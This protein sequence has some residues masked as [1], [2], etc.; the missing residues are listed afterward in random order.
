MAADVQAL[1][2]AKTIWQ[3]RRS[4]PKTG[5]PTGYDALDQQLPQGGWCAGALTEILYESPGCGELSVLLPTLARLSRQGQWITWIAPPSLPY[6]PALYAAGVDLS[7]CL[8][9]HPKREVDRLWAVEQA[10][11]SGTCAAVITWPRKADPQ[12]I[13]RL[14]LAA[15]AGTVL[16]CA[17]AS[18]SRCGHRHRRQRCA[19]TFIPRAAVRVSVFSKAAVDYRILMLW[20]CLLLPQLSVE[21]RA[22]GGSPTRALAV[23]TGEGTQRKVYQANATAAALGVNSGQSIS[24]AYALAPD[25]LVLPRDHHLEQHGREQVAGWAYRY[26]PQIGMGY[27]SAVVLEISASRKLFGGVEALLNQ[28]IDGLDTLGYSIST[29]QL[30]P[31]PPHIYWQPVTKVV[32]YKPPQICRR[33]SPNYRCTPLDCLRKHY[34][35]YVG[36]A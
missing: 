22:R 19:C 5:I 9:I 20:T 36:S 34:E 17:A 18:R 10:M 30:P 6:P 11:R 14:Q 7:H 3:G 35:V 15:E 28:L 2:D 13:R 31:H 1:L 23:T 21:V 29:V 33:L 27:E 4:L 24:A 32:R 16:G 8:L 12:S 26:S 25:L